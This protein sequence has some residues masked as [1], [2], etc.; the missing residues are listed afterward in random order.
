MIG[1]FEYSAKKKACD[2]VLLS[3]HLKTL[4]LI[5]GIKTCLFRWK[6]YMKNRS[7]QFAVF[8]LV[9]AFSPVSFAA[10]IEYQL[11]IGL[12][13]FNYAE[14]DDNNKFLD[15]ET[16]FIPGVVHKLK[17]K[18]QKTYTEFVGQAYTNTVK[19]DGQTQDGIPLK[20]KSD[21]VIIDAHFKYGLRLSRARNHG[22]Y[23]GIGFRYWLRNIRSGRDINGDA[24]AGL[25]EQYRWSYG[26]LGY[27]GNFHVSENITLGFDIRHTYMFNG[28]M[29]VDFLGYKNYDSTQVELGNRA[30]LRFA[31]P[32]QRKIRS[33]RLILSPYYEILDIGKS[34]SVR[35]TADGVPTDTTIHEPRSETRNM[36]IE[37]T[38]L[39]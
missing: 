14:Y 25:L 17:L 38:W 13:D 26:L 21:A 29:D 36:G 32:I 19:Y 34:N 20:T 12:M 8:I 4:I 9:V 11:G 30:G 28:K 37:I 15:G 39:W 35:V 7:V 18:S 3:L 1:R 22:P 24:V 6:I 5:V 23:A 27:T 10:K 33:H 2:N 31:L 16:G